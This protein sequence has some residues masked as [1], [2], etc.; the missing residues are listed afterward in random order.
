MALEGAEEDQQI[1]DIL[2]LYGQQKCLLDHLLPV[3]AD[4]MDELAQLVHYLHHKL[5]IAL[6]SFLPVLLQAL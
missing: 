5:E 6:H 3:L 1:P 4:I 2:V